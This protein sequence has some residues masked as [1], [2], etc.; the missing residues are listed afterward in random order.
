MTTLPLRRRTRDESMLDD[1][2][3]NELNQAPAPVDGAAP[4]ATGIPDATRDPPQTR[5][6]SGPV[7]SAMLSPDADERQ[8]EIADA[9]TPGT[10]AG[11]APGSPPSS[12]QGGGGTSGGG[13]G[14][15]GGSTSG[16]AD[17]DTRSA[18][19]RYGGGNIPGMEGLAPG[20]Y[21]GQSEGFDTRQWTA[22]DPGYHNRSIKNTYGLIASH[23]DVSRP[24]F[25]DQVLADPD[26]K[27][28]FPMA[29]RVGKDSIDFGDGGIV[30]VIRAAREDGSGEASV[31]QPQGG[32]AGGDG[33]GGGGASGGGGA[34]VGT[35]IDA[36]GNTDVLKEIQ[37]MLAA[38][39][40]G[41]DPF[42]TDELSRRF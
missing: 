7:S 20:Q 34:G 14:T 37:R 3:G 36:L 24:G 16:G 15:S 33:P 39:G 27:R 18:W 32:A 12:S 40:R 22:P 23:Y 30:D 28:A 10:G 9:Q 11:L 25:L 42:L 35:T 38:Q 13:G 41:E 26:F 19:A 17:T 2:I 29:K 31:W 4:L 8:H 1:A 21:A 5:A 6:D